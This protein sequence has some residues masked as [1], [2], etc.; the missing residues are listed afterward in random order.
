MANYNNVLNIDS[1]NPQMQELKCPI[2]N[3]RGKSMHVRY[4]AI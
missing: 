1:Q 4:M 2:K 3:S